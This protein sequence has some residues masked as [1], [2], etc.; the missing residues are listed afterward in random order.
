MDNIHIVIKGLSSS[1]Y[2]S[3]IV[4][5]FMKVTKWNFKDMQSFIRNNQVIPWCRC[6]IKPGQ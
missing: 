3:E 1:F 5:L 6:S 2:D 4:K